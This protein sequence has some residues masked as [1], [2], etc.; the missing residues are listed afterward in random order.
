[1]SII[2]LYILT[3]FIIKG[4]CYYNIT[5]CSLQY[6]FKKSKKKFILCLQLFLHEVAVS[7]PKSQIFPLIA[8]ERPPPKKDPRGVLCREDPSVARS[9]SPST[10]SPTVTK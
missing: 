6:P 4:N 10:S 5:P 1:M 3:H 8:K 2:L 9:Q 7:D